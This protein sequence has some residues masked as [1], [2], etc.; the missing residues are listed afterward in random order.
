MRLLSDAFGPLRSA[1]V[2]RLVL[3]LMGVN[4]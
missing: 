4:A 1:E 2:Q 3:Y